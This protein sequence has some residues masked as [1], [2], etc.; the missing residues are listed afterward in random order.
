MD[1]VPHQYTIVT[2][3]T[4]NEHRM[5]CVCGAEGPATEHYRSY[6][7]SKNQDLHY[8]YCK[9]GYLIEEDTHDM[10]PTGKL[11]MSACRDCGYLR[12]DSN[13]G[14]VIKGEKDNPEVETE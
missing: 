10:V 8:V 9:C 1:N 12:N 5:S 2:S 7:V 3:C 4:D 14:A 13:T 11:N 6:C